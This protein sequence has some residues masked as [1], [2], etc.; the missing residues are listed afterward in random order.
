MMNVS[1]AVCLKPVWD[2]CCASPNEDAQWSP[3][4]FA[5]L[6]TLS[7]RPAKQGYCTS[8]GLQITTHFSI[9]IS[10]AAE[11]A[12]IKMYYYQLLSSTH[13]LFLAAFYFQVFATHFHSVWGRQIFKLAL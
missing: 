9:Q 13:F 2:R 10:F 11:A 8:R 5:M 1:H 3:K 12:G 7:R 4:A 6:A